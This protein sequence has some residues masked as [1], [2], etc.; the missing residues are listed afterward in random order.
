VSVQLDG[1]RMSSPQLSQTFG[2]AET[3][4]GI[5]VAIDTTLT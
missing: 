4:K 1:G 3:I 2:S 5:Y